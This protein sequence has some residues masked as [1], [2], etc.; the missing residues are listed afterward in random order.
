MVVTVQRLK[1]ESRGTFHFSFFKLSV[2]LIFHHLYMAVVFHAPHLLFASLIF[3]CQSSAILSY[4]YHRKSVAE[5]RIPQI[6]LTANVTL[7]GE[8]N[9]CVVIWAEPLFMSYVSIYPHSEV[10]SVN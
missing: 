4:C 2:N 1:D 3:S 8:T 6:F 7:C 9:G 5:I 10:V